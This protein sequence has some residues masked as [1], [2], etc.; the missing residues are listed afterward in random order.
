MYLSTPEQGGETV[1]PNAEFKSTGD[2]LSDC[3]KKVGETQQTGGVRAC[4][5]SGRQGGSCRE[6]EGQVGHSRT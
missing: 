5:S 6:R 2:E 3:A 1:F 4:T